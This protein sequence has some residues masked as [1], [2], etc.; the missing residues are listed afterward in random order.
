MMSFFFSWVFSGISPY[1]FSNDA[2]RGKRF[3]YF[4]SGISCDFKVV[5]PAGYFACKSH[6]CI[7]SLPLLAFN[8]TTNTDPSASLGS[9]FTCFPN[10][11]FLLGIVSVE[12]Y[13]QSFKVIT[14]SLKAS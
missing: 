12:T 8:F 7:V 4:T 2:V 13:A 11:A 6:G 3:H 10:A 1:C 14:I 9:V 5:I